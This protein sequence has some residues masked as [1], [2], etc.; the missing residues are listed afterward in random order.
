MK[1]NFPVKKGDEYFRQCVGIDISKNKFNAC[2]FMYDI[3]G[4]IGCGTLSVE[5]PNDKHGFNQLIKWSRKE[6]QKDFPLTFLMEATGVYYEGLAYHL[7]KLN[8]TVYVVLPNKARDFC[9]YHGIKTK[10][11]EMDARCLALLGCSNSKLIPWQPPKP[12]YKSL[13][14]MTRFHEEVNDVRT[15]LT[16]HL[17][18]LR[19]CELPEQSVVKNYEKLLQKVDKQI[20]TNQKNIETLV[21]S[22]KELKKK[23]DNLC[24]IKG[25]GL[26]T[27]V[28]IVA[29]TDGFNFITSRK[30]L[31]SYAGLD[32]KASQSGNCD[33]KHHISKRGNAHIRRAL[34]F[35]AMASVRS[36]PQAKE[37]YKRICERNPRAKKIGLTAVMRKNLQLTYSLWKSG[38][39]YD[40]AYI[41]KVKPS[42]REEAERLYEY[43]P[44]EPP[45][46]IAQEN[47]APST[48]E[49]E[50]YLL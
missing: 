21:S 41:Q 31:A 35:P 44:S 12:I 14:Q 27:V 49:D 17:E 16:N 30:Q 11:D 26:M 28:T 34:Y 39:A 45:C 29:E 18:A 38:K 22:D 32:V 36:N 2:L 20:E 37:L 33:P 3:A 19:H 24:T 4:D 7:H 6:H 1:P 13:R 50:L 23:V 15:I 43:G 9:N 42:K 46:D 47:P 40:P 5:F 10:T 25:L 48:E 8:Q